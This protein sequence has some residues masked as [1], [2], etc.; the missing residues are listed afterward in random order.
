V[1]FYPHGVDMA[2]SKHLVLSFVFALMFPLCR[3][4]HENKQ[5]GREHGNCEAHNR[6][7]KTIILIVPKSQP[8]EDEYNDTQKNQQQVRIHHL[9]PHLTLLCLRYVLPR[10]LHPITD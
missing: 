4:Q 3:G 10:E 9:P 7:H 8:Y 1:R 6:R 5:E 2:H